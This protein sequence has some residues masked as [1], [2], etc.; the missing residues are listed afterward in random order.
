MAADLLKKFSIFSI[1]IIS[2]FGIILN[3]VMADQIADMSIE[4]AKVDTVS[5]ME[6]HSVRYLTPD[7]IYNN[8]S[9]KNKEIFNEYYQMLK[10]DEV[11]RIKIFDNNK[12][13]VYSDEESLIGKIYDDYYLEEA[14]KGSV[15]VEIEGKL[16]KDEN[17]LK[18]NNH[19]GFMEIYVPLRLDSGEIYGAV[20]LY[21]F[22]DSVDRDI[23]RSQRTIALISILGLSILYLSLIWIVKDASETIIKQN[24]ALKKSYEDLKG[25]DKMKTHFVQTMSHELRTPLNAIIG[26]S[27]IL[28]QNNSGLNEKQYHYVDNIYQS[29][30]HLLDLINDILDMIVIDA[31]K[32]ELSFRKTPVNTLIDEIMQNL[33]ANAEKNK[34]VIQKEIDPGLEFIDADTQRITQILTNLLDNA[35][36]F[37]KKEGGIS[38][39]TVRK[40]ENTAIFSISDNGIGIKEENL[41]RLFIAFNQLDSGISRRYGGT[42]LGLTISKNLVE[43]HGGK[44]WV[45]SKYGEGSTF[46]FEIPLIHKK[47]KKEND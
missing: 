38:K 14:L 41:N 15:R 23:A 29:G 37:S 32:M 21:R 8:D 46:S 11:A 43:L 40:T 47:E 28:K 13:I 4:R 9:Y 36:K 7:I 17:I 39:I 3:I 35:I 5:I 10:T 25:M 22:L 24:I 12:R 34:V 45:E 44:I 26:F 42:G 16:E 20:E 18:Q 6:L 19:S 27:D 31:G 2:F 33:K 1:F 30:K